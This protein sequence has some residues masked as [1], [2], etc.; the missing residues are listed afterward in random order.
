MRKRTFVK[1]AKTDRDGLLLG[2]WS[3]LA[4]RRLA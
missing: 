1:A 2:Y 3:H 4:Q